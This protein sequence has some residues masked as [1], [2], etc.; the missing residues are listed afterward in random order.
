MGDFIV[1][2]RSPQQRQ[3]AGAEAVLRFTTKTKVI[4]TEEA[5][6]TLILSSTDN[7]SLWGPYRSPEGVL[8]A[9]SGRLAL[10]EQKWQAAEAV[11]ADG[12]LA[13]KA[14]WQMFSR[15]GIK[16]VEQLGGNW[17]ILIYDPRNHQF[18]LITDP[19]G[20]FPCFRLDRED[21]L[22]F[23][24]HP[25]VLARVAGVAD[26]LDAVSMTEF[27]LTSTVTPPH[28]YYRPIRAME[29]G[30]VTTI[31][32]DAAGA[33]RLSSRRYFDLSLRY[34]TRL[35]EDDL[36][37]ELAA[38]FRT[39]VQRRTLPRLGR[40]AIALSGGLDSRAIM[41]CVENREQVFSFSCYN[42]PNRELATAQAIASSLHIPFFAWRRGLEYYGDNAEQGVR[43]SGGM[44]TF[45]NN[46][47]LGM[48][49]Q[50]QENGAQNLLTGCYCDYLFKGLPLN[51]SSH[52]LTGRERLAPFRHEFYFSHHLRPSPL[53]AQIQERQQ[54]RVPPEFQTQDSPETV[55]QI[56]ARR[57]F[58][59]YY[60]G[61][62]QQRVVPQRVMGW[63]LPMADRAIM[64]V[65]RRIPFSY[66]LNRSVYT[67]AVRRLCQGPVSRVP[68]ANTGSL[69][70]A[71][72]AIECLTNNYARVQ[73]KLRRFH[74]SVGTDG[75]WPN[76]QFYVR[77][78]HC[79]SELWKRPNQPANDFFHRVL[80]PQDI[81]SDTVDYVGKDLFFLVSLLTLKLWFEQWH[82]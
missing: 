36:A 80:S 47:F 60:E 20:A 38:A 64:E 1:D 82:S 13:C 3:L 6:F 49:G 28:T 31:N 44:G 81:R 79:L 58:P 56:E 78:S 4:V 39:A 68:D 8:V 57:T 40:T 51:R 74:Q 16:A 54:S 10:D 66:K 35:N 18:H 69:V 77:H 37:D 75:S 33:Q 14:I 17:V 19:A 24:S 50:L 27:L 42:E 7:A 5:E 63:Y 29:P 15:G 9:I 46:H 25:D 67:K 23:G 2:F 48:L 43:I 45:A 70:G 72:A 71:P 62:N 41:A 76:W 26:Q 55:F 30:T 32:L 52:W 11:A 21:S 73:R 53:A 65:Y 12:G 61:D 22:I 59:L 34:D